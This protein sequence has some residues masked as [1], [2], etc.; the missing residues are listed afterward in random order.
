MKIDYIIF[1]EHIARELEANIMLKKK[2]DNKGLKGVILPIHFNT[3]INVLKYQPRVII[4]PFLYKYDDS[5][6]AK[7]M[8]K[9]NKNLI[10]VN[11]HSEQIGNKESQSRMMPLDEKSK[12]VYHFVWGDF[13]KNL[14]I[15]DGVP[16]EIV[17]SYGSIRNDLLIRYKE[18]PI[19]PK[20]VLIPTSFSM[21]FVDS[22]YIEAAI[23]GRNIERAQFLESIEFRRKS[24][25]EFFKIINSV[26]NTLSDYEFVLRP[27]PYT[28]LLQYEN[29]FCEVNLINEIPKNITIERKGSIA[30]A[31][32]SCSSVI[33]WHSTSVLEAQ[34]MGKKVFQLVPI[35][36]GE[37]D[38]MK[39]MDYVQRGKN[40]E[41]C[42][43]FL[44]SN[45]NDNLSFN[46]YINYIYGEVDGNAS[47]RVA[48][49]IH[50]LL[51]NIDYQNSNS[52]ENFL[53]YIKLFI[54][55]ISVDF[56]KNLLLKIG[57][58]DKIKPRFK[59]ILEDHIEIK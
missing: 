21:T 27:H 24:R 11:L 55:S 14:L 25:D 43:N 34:I 36:F 54:K 28:D 23:K 47:E 12:N 57:L 45:K 20:K 2:L 1:Y 40:E 22:S 35:E 50:E 31:L 3:Y 41:D 59:G 52:L 7:V 15:K 5:Y 49:K 58:L 32:S 30:E 26:A 18:R 51:N 44:K 29:T 17:F 4:L 9:F 19:N 42:I 56:S 38:Y 33:V 53:L 8:K 39:Y 16:E 46:N 13:F 48:N 37:D 6:F 10:I